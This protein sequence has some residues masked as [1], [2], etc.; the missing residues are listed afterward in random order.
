MRRV[1]QGPRKEADRLNEDSHLSDLPASRIEKSSR[2]P[3]VSYAGVG[4]RDAAASESSLLLEVPL[5]SLSY[6]VLFFCCL[7][8]LV[9]LC[10][11]WL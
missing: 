7:D 10:H 2:I 5:H 1:S 9:K 3:D 8:G 4:F 6:S 11:R